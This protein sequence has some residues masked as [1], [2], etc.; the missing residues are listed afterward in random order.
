M[1]RESR[2]NGEGV[3]VARR[4]WVLCEILRFAQN[5][6]L[7]ERNLGWGLWVYGEDSMDDVDRTTVPSGRLRAGADRR[8]NG[9]SL[10]FTSRE[11]VC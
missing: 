2:W 4:S 7:G 6:R 11:V 8:Y 3:L 9:D 1:G 5:D 10:P